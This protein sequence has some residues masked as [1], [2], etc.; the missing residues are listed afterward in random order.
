MSSELPV[1]KALILNAEPEIEDSSE[2]QNVTVAQTEDSQ[3]VEH[4]ETNVT[5]EVLDSIVP[6]KYTNDYQGVEIKNPP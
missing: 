2:I 5:T 1:L 4:A 6:N 3:N